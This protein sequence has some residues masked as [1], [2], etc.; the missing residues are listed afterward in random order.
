MLKKEYLSYE[1]QFKEVLNNQEIERIENLEIRAIRMKYWNLQREAF[2]DERGIP[3]RE[4]HIVSDR[5]RL[6][7]QAELEPFKIK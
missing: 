6:E 3:D 2:L 5:L 7:E 1:E 4:L